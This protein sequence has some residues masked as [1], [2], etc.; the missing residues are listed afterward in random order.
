MNI[1]PNSLYQLWQFQIEISPISLCIWTVGPQL[2]VLFGKDMNS[3][4]SG[5]LLEANVSGMDFDNL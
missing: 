3:L 5:A 2:V 4:G 1:E